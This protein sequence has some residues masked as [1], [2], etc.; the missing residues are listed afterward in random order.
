MVEEF[1]KYDTVYMYAKFEDE[2]FTISGF[3][4]DADT[5][6]I[7]IFCNKIKGTYCLTAADRCEKQIRTTRIVLTEKIY[8]D[9]PSL[10]PQ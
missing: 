8:K 2:E 6:M 5:S 9:K 4:Q 10:W 1:Q 7:R 3:Y